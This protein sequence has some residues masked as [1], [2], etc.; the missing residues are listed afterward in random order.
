MGGSIFTGTVL[1]LGMEQGVVLAVVGAVLVVVLV[2]GGEGRSLDIGQGDS[3]YWT[4]AV[5]G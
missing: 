5:L 2:V 3:L 1:V 4:G